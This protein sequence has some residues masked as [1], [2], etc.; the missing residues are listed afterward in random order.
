MQADDYLD[1]S[2]QPGAPDDWEPSAEIIVALIEAGEDRKV[3][4]LKLYEVLRALG[5]RVLLLQ[6][7]GQIYHRDAVALWNHG[8]YSYGLEMK[9][10]VWRRWMFVRNNEDVFDYI[11][12]CGYGYNEINDRIESLLQ[13][14]DL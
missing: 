1:C 11:C 3:C 2:P 5:P 10:K 8:R 14:I 7:E 12:D 4:S 9:I 6:F 13:F